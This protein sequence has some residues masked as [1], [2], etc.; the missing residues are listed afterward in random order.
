MTYRKYISKVSIGASIA[1]LA[2]ALMSCATTPRGSA[3]EDSETTDAKK[4]KE[5]DGRE[6]ASM[7]GEFT[8]LDEVGDNFGKIAAE[9]SNRAVASESKH[10][11]LLKEKNWVFSY[12]PKTNHFYVDIQGVS[13][14]MAQT[15]LNDGERFA[16]AAEGQAENPVTFSVHKGEGRGTASGTSCSTE[17]SYWNKKSKSYVTNSK[18]VNGKSCERLISVLKDYV[19]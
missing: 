3:S 13:Y 11:V 10:R 7:K 15:T 14:Q 2:L 8:W 9:T 4:E 6:P 5:Y 19:P 16:F 18:N 1:I 17:I 12:L